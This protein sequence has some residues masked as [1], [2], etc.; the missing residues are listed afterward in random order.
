ML[1]WVLSILVHKSIL[2]ID[3]AEFLAKDLANKI[4]DQRFTDAHE[5]ITKLLKDFEKNK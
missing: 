3:E 2:T 5:V 4:H 1:N